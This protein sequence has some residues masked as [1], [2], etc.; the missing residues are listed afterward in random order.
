M[1]YVVPKRSTLVVGTTVAVVLLLLI[2]ILASL[3]S[4]RYGYARQVDALQPRVERLEGLVLAEE[5][6]RLASDV[7]DNT[8]LEL[9]YAPSGDVAMTS[10]DM[11]QRVRQVVT[12]AGLT[13]AGSQILP[14]LQRDGLQILRLDL[15]LS[16]GINDFD[17]ALRDLRE[18]RPLA[19]VDTASVK[20]SV[21]R[22]S[23]NKPNGARKG[24]T[25]RLRIMSLRVLN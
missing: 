15:T 9:A 21:A 10:A 19:M 20:P 1:A 5:Q 11:Q 3:W 16:G 24:L 4:W 23:R 14:P 17:Q 6:L 25:A 18:L 13:V 8:L 22:R 7:I 2:Y 12:N